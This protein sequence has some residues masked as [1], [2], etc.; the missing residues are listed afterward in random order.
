MLTTR[1]RN[2]LQSLCTSCG[3][4]VLGAMTI[5]APVAAQQIFNDQPYFQTSGQSLWYPGQGQLNY[6]KPLVYS[7][8]TG[9]R[10][11]GGFFNPHFGP[12]RI[13]PRWLHFTIPGFNLGETGL[14]AT[15]FSSG[16]M[17]VELDAGIDGGSVNVDLPISVRLEFPD[18]ETLFAGEPF[19]LNSSY[20][21]GSSAAMSSTRPGAHAKL[22]A[23]F[24]TTNRANVT[25]KAIGK[26]FL[27]WSP[28]LPNFDRRYNLIDFNLNTSSLYKEFD[29]A[30]RGIL[31][32]YVKFPQLNAAGGLVDPSHPENG[33]LSASAYDTFFSLRGNL[34]QLI[35]SLYGVSLSFPIDIGFDFN[36]G[37][38]SA[39]GGLSGRVDVASLGY[40]ADFGLR[41]NLSLR[42]NPRVRLTLPQPVAWEYPVG[43][44]QSPSSVL[45]FYAGDSLRITMPATSVSFTPTYLLPNTFTNTVNL[46]MNG[47]GVFE[48]VRVR[49]SA[50]ARI[51]ALG[52]VDAGFNLG[53]FDYTPFHFNFGQVDLNLTPIFD[54]SFEMPGF[55]AQSGSTFTVVG[56]LHDAPVLQTLYQEN[57]SD[58]NDQ[59]KTFATFYIIRDNRPPAESYQDFLTNINRNI[60][61][62][63]K[64]SNFRSNS[65]L[66]AEYHGHNLTLPSAYLNANTMRVQMPAF[67]RLLPGVARFTAETPFSLG[68]SNTL[69]FPIEYPVPFLAAAGFNVWASD[70]KFNDL[71]FP[72]RG[73]NFINS[74]DYYQAPNAAYPRRLLQQYWNQTFAA[75][76]AMEAY[77]PK[78]D[79]NRPAAVPTVY[80]DGK[81]LSPY[82]EIADSGFLPS[83][84]PR[85]AFDRSKRVLVHIVN[86]SPGGGP[87]N[88]DRFVTVGGPQ[89]SLTA[90]VP[91]ISKP[92]VPTQKVIIKGISRTPDN[93]HELN[94]A[95]YGFTAESVARWNGLIRLTRFISAAELEVELPASDFALAAD[96]QIKVET[97][98]FNPDGS[99]GLYTSAAL[100]FS[101]R[102]PIPTL[103]EHTPNPIFS[104]S[105]SFTDPP[106]LDD[107]GQ[108]V[109]N[110]VLSGTGFVSNSVVLWNN[111]PRPFRIMGENQIEVLLSP[112][113]V[114][115]P[116]NNQITVTNP[117]PGGGTVTQTIPVRNA[118]PTIE[119]YLPN[120]IV[121]G[122]PDV[123]LGIAGIGY[124]PGTR[125]FWDGRELPAT[126][127]DFNSIGTIIPASE[128]TTPRKVTLSVINPAFDGDG[129]TATYSITI[130][131]KAVTGKIILQGLVASAAPRLVTFELRQRGEGV[132]LRRN[133][134]VSPNIPI[135]LGDLPLGVFD[136]AIK[137]KEYLRRVVRIDTTERDTMPISVT[138]LAG[139][140]SWDNIVDQRDMILLRD[141]L[142]STPTSPKWNPSADIN[143]DGV[144]NTL[145]MAL[146]LANYG[147]RGSP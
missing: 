30:N 25:A 91:S 110:L 122:S 64:G 12:W 114:A 76:G 37:I 113:D 27:D 90:L 99:S 130:H 48:P 26:T 43:T 108:T 67:F 57:V 11:I 45:E 98:Y 74:Y 141:A 80:W 6:N 53:S 23:V 138:L 146:L 34:S 5:A 139:D 101:V 54:R 142:G 126:F 96:N 92:G 9:E 116:G 28:D 144:V 4:L 19:I 47:G 46:V 49:G 21:V 111:S 10:S 79:F 36:F 51:K 86:P 75:L 145:D 66:R 109:Y 44:P 3:L 1:K 131:R 78:F 100:P 72:I 77:F 16:R 69:D 38:A 39:S 60:P 24:Q 87:S 93:P 143:G 140:V 88:M 68:P 117:P 103:A 120:P 29:V 22:D 94:V 112:A 52:L 15:A 84:L 14:R 115:L 134:M 81:P 104:A 18:K 58:P 127:G 42:L 59:S 128:L 129:G 118:V 136:L 83:L 31:T 105:P 132:V 95:A 65:Y 124:F 85:E 147:K 40:Q 63:V 35:A 71:L 8:N 123:P 13:G 50:G 133:I 62:I 106:F 107:A 61:M 33:L 41:Q 121:T 73:E 70:P 7:W 2:L 17:G 137:G 32:G 97:P 55:A 56:R 89:P 125:I 20:T 119:W 102:N 135:D 82:R